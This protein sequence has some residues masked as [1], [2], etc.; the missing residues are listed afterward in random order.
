VYDVPH[1]VVEELSS[2]EFVRVLIHPGRTLERCIHGLMAA[3]GII[4]GGVILFSLLG[5]EAGCDISY[6]TAMSWRWTLQRRLDGSPMQPSRT[7]TAPKRQQ[8]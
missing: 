2:A 5:D 4:D 1:H 3:A 8:R 7:C 6:A